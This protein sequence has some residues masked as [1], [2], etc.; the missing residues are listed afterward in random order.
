MTDIGP[1]K[2]VLSLDVSFEPHLQSAL[3]RF[4]Y[5]RPDA[6]VE[7]H[8]GHVKIAL[9]QNH[10]EADQVAQDFQFCLYREKIYRETLQ[11]R[12]TMIR[13]LMGR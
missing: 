10:E 1:P 6:E 11:L 4:R 7:T 3:V 8:P 13:G 2:I 12:Q 9:S 5:L